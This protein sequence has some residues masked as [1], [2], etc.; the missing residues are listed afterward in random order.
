MRGW[1]E[2]LGRSTLGARVDG[3]GQPCGACLSHLR[4]LY[5]RTYIPGLPFRVSCLITL[6]LPTLPRS[7]CS[8]R[9]CGKKLLTNI[10]LTWDKELQ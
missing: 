9:L 1:I 6:L 8:S 5:L 7:L 3:M 2:L 10:F 4:T